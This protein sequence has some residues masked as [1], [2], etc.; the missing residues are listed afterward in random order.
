L[1]EI[2]ELYDSLSFSCIGFI[3]T[4]TNAIMHYS[5]FIFSSLKGT[6]KSISVILKDGHIN[7]AI[8]LVRKM[9]DDVMTDVYLDVSRK[10]KYDIFT[11]PI[12]ND[13][14]D[15][16]KLKLRIPRLKKILSLLEKSP[17]TSDLYPLFGWE[18]Y[19]KNNRDYLDH[20]AHGNSLFSM[21]LNCS[22]MYLGNREKQLDNIYIVLKQILQIHLSFIFHLNPE[23]LMSSDYINWLDCGHKPPEGSENWIAPYAQEAFN[24]F[25][26]PNHKLAQFIKDNCY[27][28]ID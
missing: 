1:D 17:H 14:Q 19:L 22:E 28:E 26:K 21:L 15:W 27:L 11:N 9:F 10:E 25:I 18:T 16:I 23:F 5:S 7:D 8:V 13:V 20:S 2:S 4:G 6:S 24:K 3:P 12:V